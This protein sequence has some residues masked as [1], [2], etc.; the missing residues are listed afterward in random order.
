MLILSPQVQF[1]AQLLHHYHQQLWQDLHKD[2]EAVAELPRTHPNTSELGVYWRN[3][4][5]KAMLQVLYNRY[6]SP[7][8]AG[9][10]AISNCAVG[11]LLQ[12]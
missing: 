2:Y 12:K 1:Q 11:G 10:S 6:L 3:E 4:V 5:F 9:P 7:Q 8:L